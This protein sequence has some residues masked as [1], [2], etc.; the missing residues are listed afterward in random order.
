M[1]SLLVDILFIAY[2]NIF[3]TNML[4]RVAAVGCLSFFL[5]HKPV[6]VAEPATMTRGARR[7][8]IL[9]DHIK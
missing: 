5:N 7:M 4:F 3:C 8:K 1:L 6:L 9:L 2:I